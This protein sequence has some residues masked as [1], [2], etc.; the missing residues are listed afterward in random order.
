M[1]RMYCSLKAYCATLSPLPILDVPISAARCLHAR[2]N[3]RDPSS[4]R[5][6]CVGENVPVILPK[7]RLPRHLGIFYMPQIYDMG[8]TALLPFQR[9]V[10]WG[11][12]RP[13]ISW[14]LRPCL[15]PRTWVLKG[16]TLPLDHQNRSPASS[17]EVNNV[18]HCSSIPFVHLGFVAQ[19]Y[20]MLITP[21]HWN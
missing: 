8:P 1:P 7:W 10:C 3:A 16:S 12:F 2:S 5:W 14:R 20:F 17:D 4:K 18:W 6:N 9:K 13:E 19:R 11:F 21:W 15:N